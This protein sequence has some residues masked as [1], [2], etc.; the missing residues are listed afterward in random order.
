MNS[1]NA[2]QQLP[3]GVSL[4]DEA[5]F[6]NYQ[7]GD[8][9]LACGMIRQA[10]VGKGEQFL[11]VWGSEG[12][13]CSHLLQAACHVA[14]PLRRPAVYL[15]MSEI[16]HLSPV[17]LEGMEHLSLVCIDDIQ[18]IAGHAVWEEAVFHL[19]NRIRQENNTLIVGGN[20][21]PRQLPI[22]LPDLVSRLSWGVVF[23]LLPLDDE[24]KI[25]AIKLRANLRGFKLPDDVAKYLVH[26]ASRSMNDLCQML[27]HLDKASLSAQRKVTIP[28]IKQEMGW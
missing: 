25:E 17:I 22:A 14:E 11:Y 27:D 28:F 20:A 8:N 12:V 6:E 21:A 19:F 7:V 5:R 16:I 18:L 26:H 1:T 4:R 24:N 10:A 9:G 2:P 23:Q 13:G 15:P 3:L